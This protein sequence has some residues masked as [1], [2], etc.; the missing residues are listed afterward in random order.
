MPQGAP[1]KVHTVTHPAPSVGRGKTIVGQC[2]HNKWATPAILH[3]MSDSKSNALANAIRR[4][5]RPL[6]RL[7]LR[8]GMAFADFSAIAK[9]EFVAVADEDYLLP[10]GKRSVS[11]VSVLTGI[12]RKDVKRL[13]EEPNELPAVENNRAARVIDGWLRDSDY[14]AKNGEPLPLIL[15]HSE[16]SFSSLVRKYSGDMPPRT[17]LD[18]LIRVGAVKQEGK[19]VSLCNNAYVPTNDNVELLNLSGTSM[20]D[21]LN[22]IDHNLNKEKSET[23]L[24]LSVA[25]DDVSSQGVELFKKLSN[26]K[27]AE[28]LNT[29]DTFL[30]S[31]DRSINPSIE[32][33]GQ[34][35]T[36][37]GIY[38][39]EHEI[40]NTDIS[41]GTEE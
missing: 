32:G 39:F 33:E 13:L 21:L 30:A 31:Q 16:V 23:R 6:V 34:Y 20:A 2:S 11:R 22:T 40:T 25:Y 3:W 37:M 24:Q 41:S 14:H 19:Q 10:T 18:E 36:G 26:E 29:L 1:G 7:M 15:D 38:Y 8:N 28:L 12:N 4:M 9:K 5:L 35:R 17:V 27:A